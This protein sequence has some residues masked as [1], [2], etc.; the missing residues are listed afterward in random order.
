MD[1]V[2]LNPALSYGFKACSESAWVH[3]RR[4]ANGPEIPVVVKK[5]FLGNSAVAQWPADPFFQS[6]RDHC[7]PQ[8][9]FRRSAFLIM[10]IPDSKHLSGPLFSRRVFR[11]RQVEVHN[12]LKFQIQEDFLPNCTGLARFALKKQLGGPTGV[13]LLV[14]T[15]ILEMPVEPAPGPSELK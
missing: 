6:F 12:R 14:T 7:A 15:A 10:S 3:P 11:Y 1:N 9:F 2:L 8:F 5:E 4:G 13:A